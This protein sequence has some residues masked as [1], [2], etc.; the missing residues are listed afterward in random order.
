M[1]RTQHSV[2]LASLLAFALAGCSSTKGSR[3]ETA[4]TA[5]ATASG[6]GS[7][8]TGST[9]TGGAPAAMGSGSMA[10][11]PQAQP[12]ATSPA[13]TGQMPGAMPGAMPNAI[14]MSI[15][16]MPR[17]GAVGGSGTSGATGSSMGDDKVYRITL[18]MDDGTTRVVTQEK[19]PTYRSGD[20]V[21]M[22]DGVITR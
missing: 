3:D 18:R 10:A 12:P 21:N 22:M 15:E 11:Q 14:V 13:D 17:Q 2:L 6:S 16:P 8:P 20:R 5:G 19:V 1:N 7:M 9:D 4:S